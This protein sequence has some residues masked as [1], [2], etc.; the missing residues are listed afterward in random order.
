M[1]PDP[2]LSGMAPFRFEDVEIDTVD[3]QLRRGA[4]P[5]A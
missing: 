2:R 5:R 4:P 3:D 1:G